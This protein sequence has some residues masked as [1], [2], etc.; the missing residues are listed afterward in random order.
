MSGVSGDADFVEK[1]RARGNGC[2]ALAVCTN[3]ATERATARRRRAADIVSE[4]D[5]RPGADDSRPA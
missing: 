3:G 2:G 1:L 4:A 5:A